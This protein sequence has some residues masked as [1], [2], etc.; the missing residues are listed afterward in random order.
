[1]YFAVWAKDLGTLC[2]NTTTQPSGGFF[3][4]TL[5]AWPEKCILRHLAKSPLQ[6]P[7]YFL[8]CFSCRTYTVENEDSLI[9]TLRPVEK[10]RDP[11]GAIMWQPLP[12]KEGAMKEL[13]DLL[14]I[15]LFP[16]EECILGAFRATNNIPNNT[17]VSTS[18]L[19]L[20]LESNTSKWTYGIAENVSDGMD[21]GECQE[22]N[23]CS[24]P[25]D[26]SWCWKAMGS[27]GKS[28]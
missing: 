8:P 3:F 28:L 21:S 12:W 11:I 9:L 16:K 15:R 4:V 23:L 20:S 5:E 10:E 22:P 26:C 27:K 18:K 14:K 2:C 25:I 1:M 13:L 17:C 19:S 6:Y 7:T 24:S